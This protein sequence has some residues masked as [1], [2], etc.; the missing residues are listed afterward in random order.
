MFLFWI[1]KNI[2]HIKQ[3][4]ILQNNFYFI[5]YFISILNLES[6][7]TSSC[8]VNIN[9]FITIEYI[10]LFLEDSLNFHINEMKKLHVSNHFKKE[11]FLPSILQLSIFFIHFLLHPL[12]SREIV[13]QSCIRSKLWDRVCFNHFDSKNLVPNLVRKLMHLNVLLTFQQVFLSTHDG[14]R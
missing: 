3:E 5:L 6:K 14:T 9:L 4:E 10:Q 2:L 8:F 13:K 7:H 1:H 12:S 11:T